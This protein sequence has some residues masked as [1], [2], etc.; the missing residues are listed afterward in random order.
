MFLLHLYDV[1][2]KFNVPFFVLSRLSGSL[3][4]LFRDDVSFRLNCL[5]LIQFLYN[6][7]VLIQFVCNAQSLSYILVYLNVFSL[8]F[9]LCIVQWNSLL[10]TFS[11]SRD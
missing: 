9:S 7:L 1:Y 2:T 6:A 4:K 3:T 11:W 8:D 10:M 5:L